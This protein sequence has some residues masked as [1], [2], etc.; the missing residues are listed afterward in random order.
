MPT[1][2]STSSVAAYAKARPYQL[3]ALLLFLVVAAV[4]YVRFLGE[5]P[6]GVH[7]WAQSDRYSLALMFYDY[8]FQFLKPRT[9]S[10]LSIGGITGV[11]FPL[12]P[13]LAALGGLVF[14]R[15]AIVGV[16]RAL[17]VLMAVVGFYYLFRLVYERTG[18]VA[19]GLLPGA[20]LLASP[21]FAFY[22]GNFAP[23]PFSLSLT[24]VAYYYW[25]RFFDDHRLR[26]LLLTLA[27]MTLASLVKTTSALH[28]MGLLGITGVYL[29]LQPTV[30]GL[31]QRLYVLAAVLASLGALVA[32]YL[33]NQALNETYQS[34]VFRASLNPIDTPEV[35]HSVLYYINRD[36]R[37]EYGTPTHGRILLG[38]V[39]L[40]L[41][42]SRRL[43][44]RYWPLFALLGAALLAAVV[45]WKAMGAGLGV[46][47]YHMI[48]VL[49]PPT[50]L[51]LVLALLGL[52]NLRGWL[53]HLSS[54]GLGFL[55]VFLLVK[56]YTRLGQRMSDDYLPFSA[57]Y[58]HPW[59]RGGA[60]EM[61]KAEVPASASVLV[62]NEDAPN[63]ALVYFDRRGLCWKPSNLAELSMHDLQTY[64]SSEH[65]E[66]LVMSK[67]TYEQLQHLHPQF[68]AE[69]TLVGWKP[70]LVF[71]RRNLQYPW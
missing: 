55:L 39:V 33:H 53:R 54:A 59:M 69:F 31:R 17:D 19:A 26:D 5:L 41:A 38:C 50:V 16:F 45:F 8:G 44:R 28:F 35:L 21:V 10:L 64:M 51:L 12:Q 68:P 27:L 2:F 47:D 11:E 56:G 18:H 14:G 62:L 6:T 37:L 57:Y 66:Y 48:C 32:F 23:D 9:H 15:N 24:F 7:T 60:A 70:A 22:A 36:L 25:L 58:T 13:Y 4:Y 34:I 1:S 30:L 29:L 49:G 71:Q 3:A 52:G 46:H 43:V 65:L 63:V 67:A 20:F 42:F 40:F 61:V